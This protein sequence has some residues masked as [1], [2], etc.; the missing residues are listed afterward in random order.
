VPL[1]ARILGVD[2]AAKVPVH[3]FVATLG[4]FA[5]GRMTGAQAQAA[6]EAVSG[7]PLAPDEVTTAQGI[8]ASVTS[9]GNAT[10]RV[11]RAI[12]VNDVLLLGEAGAAYTTPAAMADRI[13]VA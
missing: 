13:G 8:L 3:S 5:R 9:A 12:E 2:G 4:E 7:E 1:Y 10:A 11:L 6:I